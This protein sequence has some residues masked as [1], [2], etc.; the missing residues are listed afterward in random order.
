M[1]LEGYK[2]NKCATVFSTLVF[3]TCTFFVL[4]Q[5]RRCLM[6]FIANP[7]SSKISVES[8]RNQLFP[9]VTICADK[10]SVS[11]KGKS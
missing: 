8:T 1:D 7:K 3:L 2:K 5:S 9:T 10:N 11:R 6:K 4:I